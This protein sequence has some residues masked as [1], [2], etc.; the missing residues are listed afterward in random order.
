[1]NLR[2][3]VNNDFL[4]QELVFLIIGKDSFIVITVKNLVPMLIRIYLFH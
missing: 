3:R 1:M 2:I 4:Y